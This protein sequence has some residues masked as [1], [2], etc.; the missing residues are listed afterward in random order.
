[1][2]KPRKQTNYKPQSPVNG[3]MVCEKLHRWDVVD[4]NPELKSVKCPVCGGLTSIS[5]GLEKI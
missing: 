5:S 3:I 2:T 4:L 1:M